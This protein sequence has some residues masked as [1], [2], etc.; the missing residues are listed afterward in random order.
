MLMWFLHMLLYS[1]GVTKEKEE[2]KN[3]LTTKDNFTWSRMTNYDQNKMS[4]S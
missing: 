2:D 1:V 3:N 4:L